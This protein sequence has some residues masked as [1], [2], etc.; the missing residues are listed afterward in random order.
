MIKKHSQKNAIKLES[1]KIKSM[2]FLLG[3]SEKKNVKKMSN[4]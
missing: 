2:L 3:L 4:L 1:S